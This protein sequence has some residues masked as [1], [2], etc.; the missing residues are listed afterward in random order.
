MIAVINLSVAG[1]GLVVGLLLLVVFAALPL[2]LFAGVLT[3]VNAVI[4]PVA[5]VAMTL[6]YGDAV[7]ASAENRD[8]EGDGAEGTDGHQTEE[9][10]PADA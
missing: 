8:I 1:F 5:A 2:W 3:L 9:L 6:L 10:A 7:A 4:T